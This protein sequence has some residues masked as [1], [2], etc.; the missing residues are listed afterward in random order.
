EAGCIN[1]LGEGPWAGSTL[2]RRKIE[3]IACSIND[4]W[5]GLFAYPRCSEQGESNISGRRYF[6][7][8][9]PPFAG[10]VINVLQE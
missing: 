5:G 6:F 8:Y 1:P 2:L 7:G 9:L 3:N 4:S 10:A